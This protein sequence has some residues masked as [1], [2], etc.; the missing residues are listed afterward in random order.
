MGSNHDS[1]LIQVQDSICSPAEVTVLNRQETLKDIEY[2]QDATGRISERTTINLREVR[3][4][5][6]VL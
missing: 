5:D 4:S 3:I 1:W 6:M 2:F